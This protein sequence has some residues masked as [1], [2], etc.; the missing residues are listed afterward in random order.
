MRYRG[1]QLRSSLHLTIVCASE[2]GCACPRASNPQPQP[3]LSCVDFVAW[4]LHADLS[5]VD[6]DYEDVAPAVATSMCMQGVAGS[7]IK[8]QGLNNYA[9][10][11]TSQVPVHL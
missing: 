3:H 10:A 4:C 11:C 5:G 7:E 6:E 1:K 8:L 2:G 9:R